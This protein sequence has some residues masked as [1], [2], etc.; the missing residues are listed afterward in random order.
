MRVVEVVVDIIQYH[1]HPQVAVVVLKTKL[2]PLLY[3]QLLD[4]Q[5][6]VA[7]VGLVLVLVVVH[8]LLAVLAALAS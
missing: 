6:Q 3:R 7:V 8:L 4:L 1:Q 5:I 2:V